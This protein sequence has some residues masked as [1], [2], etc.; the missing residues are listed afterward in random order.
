MLLLAG[1]ITQ[2]VKTWCNLF[3]V[4][5]WFVFFLKSLDAIVMKL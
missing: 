4:V 3:K 1:G 5:I 2:Q